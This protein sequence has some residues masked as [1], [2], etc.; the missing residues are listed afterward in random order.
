MGYMH[1]CGINTLAAPTHLLLQMGQAWPCC[2]PT[3]CGCRCKIC[4]YILQKW[5]ARSNILDPAVLPLWNWSTC[6]HM[7]DPL[8]HLFPD[9]GHPSIASSIAILSSHTVE[10]KIHIC[11]RQ[12]YRTSMSISGGGGVEIRSPFTHMHNSL[13]HP[14]L[15]PVHS[16]TPSITQLSSHTV[17]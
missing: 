11:L 14:L 15:N 6:A 2:N 7:H 9:S 3:R 5:S 17:E 12:G 4:A 1:Q 16:S 8:L 10:Y 13:L